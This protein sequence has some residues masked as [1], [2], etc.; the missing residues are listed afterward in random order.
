MELSGTS[1]QLSCARHTE[2]CFAGLHLVAEWAQTYCGEPL[3]V[4]SYSLGIRPFF[5]T[6]ACLA[7]NIAL[8]RRTGTGLGRQLGR[9]GAS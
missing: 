1:W 8:H 5:L 2:C 4:L 9:S 6:R 3:L 7:V